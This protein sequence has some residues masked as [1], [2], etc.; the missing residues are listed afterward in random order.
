VRCNEKVKTGFDSTIFE[1][2]LNHCS[3]DISDMSKIL[4]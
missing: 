2:D 3:M 4:A 1:R